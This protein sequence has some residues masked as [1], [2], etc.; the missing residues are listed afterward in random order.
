[1]Q[2]DSSGNPESPDVNAWH[3]LVHGLVDEETAEHNDSAGLHD[4]AA[5]AQLQTPVS[6][7]SCCLYLLDGL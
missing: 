5:L 4:W 2:A 3:Q 6:D 7:Y 1:M